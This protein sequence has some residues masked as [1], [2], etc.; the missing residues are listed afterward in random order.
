MRRRKFMVLIAGAAAAWPLAARA[1]GSIMP[2]VGF[3]NSASADG[4]ALMAAAFRRGLNEVGYA[5]GQNVTI[6]YRW[7]D[8]Q[9][10]R[11]PALAADLVNRRV[12]LIFANSPS[13][14]AA[15]AA[16]KTIPII[17]NS[18]DDP[19]RLGFVASLNRPGGNATGMVIFSGQLAAK[20]LELLRELTPGSK[21]IA[22]LINADFGPSA[23]FRADVEAAARALGVATPILQASELGEIET[24][25]D[26]LAQTRPD[27][28][29]VGPGP[30]LDSHR[31]L[32]ITRAAKA[33]IPAAF[34][35]RASALAG[36]LISYGADVGDAYRQAGVYAGRVLRGE[37]PADLPVV[38]VTKLDLVINLKTAKALGLDLPAK[39]LALA[40][41][42]V[43]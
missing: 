5:E 12:N 24:A 22:V 21:T 30:F 9:Y 40:D 26:N 10:E 3:L 41:E 6:E 36:G 25:F 13:I 27:A 39:V 35:T 28:L 11:L 1:Q 17:F 43:E 18:G 14:P 16:T 42:V 23:R 31:D 2:T 20:R 38:Q 37:K 8:N 19:V 34:E 29:L 15:L 32:L 4:Y 33:A 7:A